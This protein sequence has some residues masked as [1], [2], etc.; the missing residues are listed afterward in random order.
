MK[1]TNKEYVKELFQGKFMIKLN[2]LPS[3]IRQDFKKNFKKFPQSS[4][5]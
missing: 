1:K 4:I 2:D 5:I 3:E